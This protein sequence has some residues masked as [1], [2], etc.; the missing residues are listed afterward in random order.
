MAREKHQYYYV[1]EKK[2]TIS[3]IVNVILQMYIANVIV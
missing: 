3:T 2:S 1:V